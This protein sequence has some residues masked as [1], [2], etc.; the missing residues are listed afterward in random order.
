MPTVTS[1]RYRRPKT[2]DFTKPSHR[3]IRVRL[4]SDADFTC[5]HCGYRPE[6]SEIPNPYDGRHTV[7]QLVIDHIVSL[8]QGGNRA[9][10]NLQVLCS[11]CNTKKGWWP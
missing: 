11:P 7:G 1:P 3:A 6:P 8:A 5:Q 2:F 10:D 9:G 4:Y